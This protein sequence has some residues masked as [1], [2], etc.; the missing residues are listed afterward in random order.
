MMVNPFLIT[1]FPFLYTVPPV[2]VW[3]EQWSGD[4]GNSAICIPS[5]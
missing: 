4:A 5:I 3:E 2:P 1:P